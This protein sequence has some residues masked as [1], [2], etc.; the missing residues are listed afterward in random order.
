MCHNL[1]KFSVSQA[2]VLGRRIECTNEVASTARS[3][4]C[5]RRRCEILWN[6]FH[7]HVIN[8]NGNSRDNTAFSILL[9]F[10]RAKGTFLVVVPDAT[11]NVPRPAPVNRL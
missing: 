11:A 3:D 1:C 5:R 8:S 6:A 10:L 7:T 2:D 4:R 9:L